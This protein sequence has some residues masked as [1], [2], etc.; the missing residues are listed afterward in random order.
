MACCGFGFTAIDS[1]A[2]FSQENDIY[3]KQ[4][5]REGSSFGGGGGANLIKRI[6]SYADFA[7]S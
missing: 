1:F 5:P 4:V 7:C 2:K 3:C 6:E